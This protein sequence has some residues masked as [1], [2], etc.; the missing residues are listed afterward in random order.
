[1]VRA[2]QWKARSQETKVNTE[3]FREKVDKIVRSVQNGKTLAIDAV[4]T[5]IAAAEE[6]HEWR[7]EPSDADPCGG[8]CCGGPS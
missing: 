6:W 4:P 3:Q 2:P 1:M 7:N 8:P 5:I